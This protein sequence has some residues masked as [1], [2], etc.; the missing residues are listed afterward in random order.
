MDNRSLTNVGSECPD[1]SNI[2]S[3]YSAVVHLLQSFEQPTQRTASNVGGYSYNGTHHIPWQATLGL[4]G[5]YLNQHC[6][7]PTSK[8][9]LPTG[10]Q[11]SANTRERDSLTVT[12]L[13]QHCGAPQQNSRSTTATSSTERAKAQYL[14]GSERCP[15]GL[16]QA[17][18]G[19]QA[20]AGF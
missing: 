13:G 16:F 7:E 18:V 14:R 20:T 8:T 9:L 5:I 12:R 11:R 10:K 4:L 3:S 1:T 2:L 15:L 17:P 6:L 19:V